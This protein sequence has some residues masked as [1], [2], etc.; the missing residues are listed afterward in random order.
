MLKKL[1]KHEFE[2]TRRILLPLNLTIVLITVVGCLILCTDILQRDTSLPLVILLIILYAL[3]MI[4][5]TLA[6][7]I[8]S[9]VRF[10]KNLFTSE[11]YLMF[12]LPVTHTQLL[13]SK[14]IV[15]FLWNCFNVLLTVGSIFAISFSS[16]YYA[17]AHADSANEKS[18]FLS[19]FVS[20]L[21]GG[22]QTTASFQDIFGYG[23]LQLLVICCLSLIVGCFFSLTMGYLAIALGQLMERHKLASSIGF[24]IAFYIVTQ[25]LSSILMIVIN[26][27]TLL[28][29]EL[30]SLTLTR[31]IYSSFLPATCIFNLILGVIFYLITR[32]IIRRKVNLE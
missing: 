4:V 28:G 26:L 5:L 12:T 16:S 11:G 15:A 6:A 7:Y 18:A 14:L 20:A 31:R 21:S 27:N 32:L 23:P 30:D 25:I 24:Y 3:S 29:T 10:Y 22:A 2:A 13:N 9:M 1:M 8:Y 17:I 19:G